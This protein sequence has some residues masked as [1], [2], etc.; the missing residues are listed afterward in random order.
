[1]PAD[2][3]STPLARFPPGETFE[4]FPFSPLAGEMPKAEGGSA[5]REPYLVIIR[6]PPL[7]LRDISP[8]KGG[9]GI[10]EYFKG[11]PVRE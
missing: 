2:C 8:R 4:T 7:S 9:E 6:R 11:L 3:L 5:V 10:R 1:M